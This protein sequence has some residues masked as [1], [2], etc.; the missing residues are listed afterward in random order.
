MPLKKTTGDPKYTPK[1]ET[2]VV[3]V[4][5]NQNMLHHFETNPFLLLLFLCPLK[6]FSSTFTG[7]RRPK[8]DHIFEALGNTDELSSAIG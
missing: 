1:L 3:F 6:G 7:E 5:R 2:K 4:T 8:E